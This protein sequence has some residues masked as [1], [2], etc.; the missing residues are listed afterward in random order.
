MQCP[1]VEELAPVEPKRSMM[2][3]KEEDGV[4]NKFHI[5]D[6]S[7]NA[8]NQNSNIVAVRKEL[9]VSGAVVA[10]ENVIDI[11]E[12]RE[13]GSKQLSTGSQNPPNQSNPGIG[14][15]HNSLDLGQEQTN[16]NEAWPTCG[17]RDKTD[18]SASPKKGS[19]KRAFKDLRSKREGMPS[20][21]E[22]LNQNTEES[23]TNRVDARQVQEEEDRETQPFWEGLSS[24]DEILQSRA[25]RLAKDRKRRRQM[26]RRMRKR[27]KIR[28]QKKKESRNRAS[29]SEDLT[30]RG[31]ASNSQSDNSTQ[32][33]DGKNSCWR[34]AEELWSVGKQL[35]L[36]DKNNADEVIQRLKEMEERDRAVLAI[37]KTAATANRGETV[38]CS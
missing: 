2:V 19:N 26:E 5:H 29:L 30:K 14:P 31:E 37:Q 36:V 11:L 9:E 24:E 3:G 6:D 12:D 38:I 1:A 22:N 18:T 32:K 4:S 28:R 21:G 34:E 35:G 20:N 7:L 27:I 33:H 23:V 10:L 25:E 16:Q 17:E 8:V 15:R 13:D